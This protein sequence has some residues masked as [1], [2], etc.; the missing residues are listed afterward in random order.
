MSRL[1][2]QIFIFWLLAVSS[3][4]QNP[5]DKGDPYVSRGH[6]TSPNGKYGCYVR[7]NYPIRYELIET[8]DGK[9]LA[10]VKAY[11]PEVENS[12]IQYAHAAGVYWN[13]DGTIVALD[14]LNRRRA[15]RLY[16]FILRN[17]N[18]REMSSESVV[19]IPAPAVEGRAVVDPGWT[20]RTK[21]RIRLALKARDGE[22]TSRFYLIDFTDPERPVAF[23]PSSSDSSVSVS[24]SR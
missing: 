1:V 14:E 22:I 19:P 5:P 12:N 7:T 18:V 23:N 8:S 15:G 21:I 10:T 11:Y 9:V 24:A 2:P 13:W 17:G 4:A 3:G 20:S 6:P 16:F